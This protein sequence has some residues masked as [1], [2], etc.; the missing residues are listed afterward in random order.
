MNYFYAENN[1][2]VTYVNAKCKQAAALHL[3]YIYAEQT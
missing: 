2:Q 1:V 3:L